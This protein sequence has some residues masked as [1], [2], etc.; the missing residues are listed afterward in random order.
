MKN[1]LQLIYTFLVEYMLLI[2]CL[3]RVTSV[4]ATGQRVTSVSASE[5]RVNSVSASGQRVTSVSAT[6]HITCN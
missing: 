2:F 5:Q 3:L 1:S 4:S 6:L